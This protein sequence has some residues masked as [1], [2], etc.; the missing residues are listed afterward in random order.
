M[1]VFACVAGIHPSV[2]P[3]RLVDSLLTVYPEGLGR[4]GWFSF[5]LPK[6]DPQVRRMLEILQSAGV[7][8]DRPFVLPKR[9][10][11]F[12]FRLHRE[13]DE[14][15]VQAAG[16][17]EVIP[18]ARCDSETE[19]PGLP[20]TPVL[21]RDAPDPPIA[22]CE[23]GLIVSRA[24][25]DAIAGARFPEVRFEA[26][27]SLRQVARNPDDSQPCERGPYWW[28]RSAIRMPPFSPR[29]VLVSGTGEPR[30]PGD[31]GPVFILDHPYSRAELRYAACDVERI[32][33]FALAE[34]HERNG[35]LD[36]CRRHI[37]TQ[38]FRQVLKRSGLECDWVPV[39]IDE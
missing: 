5:R 28:V 34:S 27:P 1:K 4:D 37:A 26:I 13:Y 15:D 24:G 38:A 35:C 11:E 23:N 39:R 30:K 33:E 10:G 18:V 21:S 12:W 31:Q 16:L 7:T 20:P 25:R 19:A 6:D 2:Y 9:P 32:G 29:C 3:K 17:L 14:A 22:S 8:P 36:L